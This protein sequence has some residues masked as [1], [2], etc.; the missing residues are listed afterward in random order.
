[1]ASSADFF[2]D[3]G[4][5]QT[6]TSHCSCGTKEAEKQRPAASNEEEGGS[7]RKK[8]RWGRRC[9]ND[10][11]KR[12]TSRA[13]A[14]RLPKA[15]SQAEKPSLL[16]G[17]GCLGRRHLTVPESRQCGNEA[18]KQKE[19]GVGLTIIQWKLRTVLLFRCLHTHI[20]TPRVVAE[21][22]RVSNRP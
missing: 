19:T 9:W 4:E 20:H 17:Y 7:G 13:N 8:K 11:P 6:E 14:A 21:N 10:C 3:V 1:M 15:T 18:L 12:V 5:Y 16:R 2:S 22:K